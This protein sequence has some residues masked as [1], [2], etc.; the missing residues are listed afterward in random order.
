ML[1]LRRVQ[2]NANIFNISSYGDSI[3]CTLLVVFRGRFCG[4][5][6]VLQA[7]WQV[8]ECFNTFSSLCPTYCTVHRM[9]QCGL[10]TDNVNQLYTHTRKC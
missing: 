10:W 2:T 1:R 4:A 7:T 8:K 9:R 5:M 3:Y 6:S